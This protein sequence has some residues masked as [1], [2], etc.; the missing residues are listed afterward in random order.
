MQHRGQAKR[1]THR[2]ITGRLATTLALV[3]CLALTPG[4]AT[5]QV[6]GTLGAVPI[7][8]PDNLANFVIDRDA[9]IRLGKALFWDMQVGSDGVQACASCHFHAGADNRISNQV[10]PGLLGGDEVFAIGGRTNHTF[11]AGDFPFHKLSNPEFRATDPGAVGESTV[12]SDVNDVAASQGVALKEFVDIV[13]GKAEDLMRPRIDGVFT[14]THRNTRRV[15]P[16]NTP[17]VINAVFNY[18]NFWD[19][20]ANFFFNGV[21]PFGVQDASSTVLVVDA[22]GNIVE[23]SLIDFDR[24]EL[25]LA[26]S[27]LASQ[28]V[29]PPLSDFEMSAAMRTFPKIGK[30]LLS[31][32]PLGKQVV[33]PSD[34]VLG[35]LANSGQT[36]GA[37]GLSTS[38]E[39]MIRAAFHPRYWDSTQVVVFDLDSVHSHEADTI[40]PRDFVLDSGD[41]AIIPDHGDHPLTT[42][43]YSL[44]EANF[45]LIFGLA[46]QMYEATLISDDTPFDRFLEGDVTALTDRQQRGFGIF[47]GQGNCAECHI[48]AEFTGASVA[49]R[50]SPAEPGL[51]ETM[52]MADGLLATYDLGF[53][54]ISVTPNDDDAG[55]GGSDPFGNPL[56]FSGQVV[57]KSGLIPGETLSFD[58]RFVPS[59]ECVPDPF[60]TPPLICPAITVSRVAAI[61]AFKVPGLRNVEL[62]GPFFHNGG[63]LTL[64]QVVDF[65]VRGGN[66]HEANID[67]LD[68]AIDN[69]NGLKRGEDEGPD[70]DRNAL[71]DFLMALTD[72]RVRQEM[73]PFDHPQLLVPNGHSA[74]R[75][76]PPKRHRGEAMATELLEVPAVGAGGRPAE[77][78]P[79]LKPFLMPDG[80]DPFTW[81]SQL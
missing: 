8:E 11:T 56:A 39:A 23:Q 46:V 77:S 75:G 76:G 59:P 5:A 6:A 71:V 33:H 16:R 28:A 74:F 63:A 47:N 21:N 48:G 35:P 60:V 62:T 80:V 55:R 15:E 26:K 61:G 43:E 81:H 27:S 13:P 37:K 50:L 72:E 42:D 68:P 38:Y 9:A 58:E 70:D 44:M 19:G 30:K 17:S 52:N 34:S 69:I 65:Y 20:R 53:Y 41:V 32:T 7:P 66:F 25:H 40:N 45:T 29:G 67:N 57:V 73:A 12:L 49:E 24:P 18:A 22:A 3:L 4:A 36:P 78:L 14:R 64:R 1:F 51:I 54:N 10:S 31:L 2:F 79:P